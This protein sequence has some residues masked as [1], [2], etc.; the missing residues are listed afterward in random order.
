MNE[1]IDFCSDCFVAQ[2]NTEYPHPL[3]HI[4]IG[5]R[6]SNEY[7]SQSDDDD[8]GGDGNYD[9]TIEKDE[10]SKMGIELFDSGSK[11]AYDSEYIPL[12]MIKTEI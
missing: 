6:I 4:F 1:S 3:H 11:V 10:D 8:S 5:L 9:E 7:R 12:D 2:L